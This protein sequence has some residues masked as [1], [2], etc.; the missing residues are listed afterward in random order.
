[1]SPTQGRDR[2]GRP[3][4]TPSV[5]P[6]ARQTSLLEQTEV[7]TNLRSRGRFPPPMSAVVVLSVGT[8]A[9]HDLGTKIG[10]E[11]NQ[12]RSGRISRHEFRRRAAIHMGTVSGTVAGASI[13][14]LL[15]RL[16]PGMG[17][18]VG[19]F[20]GGMVGELFGEKTGRTLSRWTSKVWPEPESTEVE[21]EVEPIDDQS[22]EP[23]RR[24][25]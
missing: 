14:S 11:L 25:L 23:V 15:G 20:A 9:V 2:F 19:A 13:G 24:D 3:R 7:S 10:R 18:V 4:R 16:W 6:P 12:L 22:I 5:P 21:I 1:M 17:P 8:R